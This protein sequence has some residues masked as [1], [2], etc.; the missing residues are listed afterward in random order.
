MEDGPPQEDAASGSS[1]PAAGSALDVTEIIP[2]AA[3]SDSAESEK[4][5]LQNEWCFWVL[6]H[7]Q[8]KKDNWQNAQKNV[9]AFNT[10]EDFWRLHNNIKS[11]S[12]LGVV[13]F[14]L[15]KKDITPAW[16]DETCRHGGRWLAKI[17]KMKPQ[18]FD[19]MW[20]NLLLT[21]IG[22]GFGEEGD[23]ICGAV[24]SFRAKNS[25]IALWL[26]KSDE[27]QVLPQGRAFH[28]HLQDFGFVAD[29]LFENFAQSKA[30]M[31]L[32]G[33]GEVRRTMEDPSFNP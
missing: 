8:T 28:Q 1:A 19:S 31:T 29:V 15:F 2:P 16:E 30:T 18:D 6:L 21:M 12:R 11:P 24:V 17:D 13:D 5:P 22:E 26:S 25:K 9:Y 20:L 3:P 14:S 10:V 23:C 27:A 4:H 33:S 7:N 32:T